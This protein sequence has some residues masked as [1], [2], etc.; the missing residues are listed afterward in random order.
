MHRRLF[1][2]WALMISGLT[3][4]FDRSAEAEADAEARALRQSL[5]DE[6]AEW[7]RMPGFEYTR[8]SM[9]PHGLEVDIFINGILD[10]A[11]RGDAAPPW[12][13]GSQ[14][15]KM[16]YVDDTPWVLSMMEKR[17]D[18]WFFAQFTADGRLIEAGSTA[19]DAMCL[20]CHT[21]ERDSLISAER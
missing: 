14:A 11:A 8:A 18:G 13:V 17:A 12:P 7:P 5:V 20:E 2:A 6:Y 16:S 21:T 9:G 10:E 4:C 3:G 1:L 19:S 15:V